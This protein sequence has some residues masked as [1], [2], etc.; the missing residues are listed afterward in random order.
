M[1]ADA[2]ALTARPAD[3]P[4]PHPNMSKEL[5]Y[6]DRKLRTKLG[7]TTHESEVMREYSASL[8]PHPRETMR[9]CSDLFQA[10]L[11]VGGGGDAQASNFQERLGAYQARTAARV[12]EM[13]RGSA[14]STPAL[15]QCRLAL[16]SDGAACV[17]VRDGGG[18]KPQTVPLA[19]MATVATAP[20]LRRLSIGMASGDVHDVEL[21]NDRALATWFVGLLGIHQTIGWA[22]SPN[23][24]S[25][26]AALQS[27]SKLA[28]QGAQIALDEADADAGLEA[29][30]SAVAAALH[31]ANP[32]RSCVWIRRRAD[33]YVWARPEPIAD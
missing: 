4:P 5:R 23:P 20:E 17:L 6:I 15:G 25:A 13:K 33:G 21:P 24:D 27:G 3:A 31:K 1:P 9:V 7:G 2:D 12:A 16:S 32:Y 8:P 26:A 14:A 28:W 22:A 11:R 29:A 19:E 30:L 18:G 10:L